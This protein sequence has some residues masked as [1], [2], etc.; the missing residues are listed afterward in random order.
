MVSLCSVGCCQV[1]RS[2]LLSVDPGNMNPLLAPS[3][4]TQVYHRKHESRHDAAKHATANH[5]AQPFWRGSLP[6]LSPILIVCRILNKYRKTNIAPNENW[7][8]E[9]KYSLTESQ[10]V[11]L[12]NTNPDLHMTHIALAFFRKTSVQMRFPML[13]DLKRV[14]IEC[15][16]QNR[17]ELRRMLPSC[18]GFAII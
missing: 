15:L 8:N 4:R 11:R 14:R 9:T 7:I 18:L 16:A 1:R 2:T 12:A 5:P 17:Y 13:L 6:D 3:F 10:C